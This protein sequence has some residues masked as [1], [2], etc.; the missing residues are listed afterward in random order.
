M[1]SLQHDS[2]SFHRPTDD[3]VRWLRERLFGVALA[4]I[5]FAVEELLG[6]DDC[7]FRKT[8]VET[9]DFDLL[10]VFESLLHR[11]GRRREIG[12]FAV[13]FRFQFRCDLVCTTRDDVDALVN[14]AGLLVEIDEFARYR[15]VRNVL[16][17][18][19][20]LLLF[21]YIVFVDVVLRLLGVAFEFLHVLRRDTP[22]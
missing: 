4:V 5:Y 1:F 15:V 12:E 17:D 3:G 9:R 2:V 7:R 8:L 10:A 21:V 22:R 20:F 6:S 16:L 19:H 14:V 11:V 18:F 13:E